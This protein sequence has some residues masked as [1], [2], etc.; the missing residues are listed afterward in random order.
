MSSGEFS[1]PTQ[2][3][4]FEDVVDLISKLVEPYSIGSSDDYGGEIEFPGWDGS[5][6]KLALE[7][8][9]AVQTGL[10]DSVKARVIGDY[11]SGIAIIMRSRNL[12]D[13]R[14]YGFFLQPQHN[15][16]GLRGLE[17]WQSSAQKP[18]RGAVYWGIELLDREQ[19]QPS[20]PAV[21]DALIYSLQAAAH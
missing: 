11:E 4:N 9:V 20:S 5:I 18:K 21:S 2:Q 17:V 14:R 16:E 19:A 10:G 3:P 8:V 12:F 6:R 7:P 1:T 13:G 15:R